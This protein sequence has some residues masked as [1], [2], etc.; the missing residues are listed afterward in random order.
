MPARTL[1]ELGELLP[2]Y[3]RDTRGNLERIVATPGPHLTPRQHWG[4][5]LAVAAAV[6]SPSATPA[7][8]FEARSRLEPTVVGAALGA[9]SVMATN[10]VYF[11]ARHLLQYDGLRAGLRMPL[12]GGSGAP[13]VDYEL[14]CAAVSAV[15]GCESCLA[16]HE[17]SARAAGATR[18]A[19]HDALRVAAVVAGAAAVLDAAT[20]L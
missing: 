15:S 9:A 2:A 19:V 20:L 6:R 11:R 17:G 5:V 14:W 3:A 7:L 8:A 13:R 12:A 10:N 1:A 16:E 4:T 18:E